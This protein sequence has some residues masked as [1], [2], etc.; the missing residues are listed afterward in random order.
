MEL[1]LSSIAVTVAFLALRN[2]MEPKEIEIRYVVKR[3]VN[4]PLPPLPVSPKLPTFVEMGIF[5]NDN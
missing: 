2:S 1:L 4:P 5:H 3:A